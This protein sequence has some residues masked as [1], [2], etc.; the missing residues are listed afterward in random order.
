MLKLVCVYVWLG[1]TAVESLLLNGPFFFF[2]L[3]VGSTMGL[4]GRQVQNTNE[5]SSFHRNG[6]IS[7]PRCKL[8]NQPLSLF[9]FNELNWKESSETILPKQLGTNG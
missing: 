3:L 6:V 2:F 4:C 1:S 5:Q 9:Q 7:P 8:T